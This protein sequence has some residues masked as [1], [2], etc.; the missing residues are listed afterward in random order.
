MNEQPESEAPRE[1]GELYYH[2]SAIVAV[3]HALANAMEGDKRDLVLQLSRCLP[4]TMYW[5]DNSKNIQQT[6]DERTLCR[7]VQLGLQYPDIFGDSTLRFIALLRNGPGPVCPIDWE[8]P[9]RV[10]DEQPNP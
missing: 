1:Y 10:A 2:P 4:T 7:T 5:N 6:E 8:H 9:P 3:L